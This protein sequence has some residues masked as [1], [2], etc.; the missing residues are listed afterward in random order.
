QQTPPL[1]QPDA[2][3]VHRERAPPPKTALEWVRYRSPPQYMAWKVGCKPISNS[4]KSRFDN[5]RSS[6]KSPNHNDFRKSTAYPSFP[7]KREPRGRKVRTVAL[8]PRIR[9]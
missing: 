5:F 4:I 9:G 3:R 7:R 8:D 2:G 1:P 6:P